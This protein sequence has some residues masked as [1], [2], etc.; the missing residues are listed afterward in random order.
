MS[1]EQTQTVTNTSTPL[2]KKKRTKRIPFAERV[3]EAPFDMDPEYY[4]YRFNDTGDK[5]ARAL[6]AG[7]EF[8]DQQGKPIKSGKNIQDPEQIG[9]NVSIPVGNGINGIYMRQPMKYHEQDL[10]AK[11]KVNDDIMR[12]IE[13]RNDYNKELNDKN[14]SE[15][16]KAK[17]RIKIEESM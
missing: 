7:Y 17:D 1:N 15:Y 6:R 16:N 10:K 5:V 9:L 11:K 13:N 2:P 4:Y 3:S 12:D 8:V 14:I